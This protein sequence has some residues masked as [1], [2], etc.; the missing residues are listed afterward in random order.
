MG[1]INW[2]FGVV[3]NQATSSGGGG[4]GGSPPTGLT[5]PNQIYTAI[6][7]GGAVGFTAHT[8][9]N[10]YTQMF[11]NSI[12]PQII[13]PF[14]GNQTTNAS[15]T[16]TDLTNPQLNGGDY[17]I[18]LS[19][20]MPASAFN[21]LIGTGFTGS[22]GSATSIDETF[23]LFGWFLESPNTGVVSFSQGDISILG[24]SANFTGMGIAAKTTRS[25]VGQTYP[26][27]DSTSFTN[28]TELFNSTGTVTSNSHLGSNGVVTTGNS[29]VFIS[30]DSHC[31]C[32]L[33]NFAGRGGGAPTATAGQSMIIQFKVRGNTGV[34]TEATHFFYE[35]ILT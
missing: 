27:V 5:P 19:H 28:A 25:E 4:G 29:T 20:S 23:F 18:K 17:T 31:I 9:G 21:S 11:Q 24:A 33:R 14:N 6:S 12:A 2:Q 10:N 13:T 8:I 3:Q 30:G 22:G 32:S 1:G 26:L 35:L 34:Q 7:N 15:M 16:L